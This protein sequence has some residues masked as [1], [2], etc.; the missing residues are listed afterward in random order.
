MCP[1][2][3]W[4]TCLDSLGFV[5]PWGNDLKALLCVTESGGNE[6]NVAVW[7]QRA[8]GIIWAL[9]CVTESGGND[10]SIAVCDRERRELFERCCV[11]QRAEGMI[12]ALFCDRERGEGR[13]GV[14]A[15]LIAKSH[16]APHTRGLHCGR[17]G[18]TL[19]KGLEATLVRSRLHETSG[20]LMLPYLLLIT[21]YWILTRSKLLLV[22]IQY[23]IISSDALLRCLADDITA[24]EWRTSLLDQRIAY[25]S[26]NVSSV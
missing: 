25:P 7:W 8:E 18:G 1:E 15:F 16:W 4:H 9:L 6:W 17:R 3:V 12:W 22:S 14:L 23:A 10:L 24:E 2:W 20:Q 5:T 11:W 19:L 26:I 13:W 21:A